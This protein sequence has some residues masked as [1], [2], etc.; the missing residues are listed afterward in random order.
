MNS[1]PLKKPELWGI[2]FAA[3]EI[4][5]SEESDGFTLRLKFPTKE[6]LA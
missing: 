1:P 5:N 6:I 4:E 2:L 3:L